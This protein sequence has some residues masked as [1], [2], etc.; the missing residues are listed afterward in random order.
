MENRRMKTQELNSELKKIDGQ[1]E[2]AQKEI[3]KVDQKISTLEE[4]KIATGARI[5]KFLND[6]AKYSAEV[7]K[8]KAIQSEISVLLADRSKL[9]SKVTKLKNRTADLSNDYQQQE[10]LSAIFSDDFFAPNQLK[11]ICLILREHGIGTAQELASR[12]TTT[13][14]I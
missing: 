12:I 10:A 3:F 11:A 4:K 9:M 6:E 14:A 8:A 1:I 13:G 7:D 2:Q 5:V